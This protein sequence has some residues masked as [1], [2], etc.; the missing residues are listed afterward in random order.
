MQWNKQRV[1][2]RLI[3]VLFGVV[4]PATATA[5]PVCAGIDACASA[6]DDGKGNLA[7]CTELG[8]QLLLPGPKQAPKRAADAFRQGCGISAEFSF[9][10]NRGEA[11]ACW[12]L[13]QLRKEGWL[14]IV[15]RDMSNYLMLVNRAESLAERKCTDA[16]PSGCVTAAAALSALHSQIT[17]TADEVGKPL[18]LA[19]LGCV[20]GKDFGACRVLRSFLWNLEYRDQKRDDAERLRKA[21]AQVSLST[22]I[23]DGGEACTIAR[24]EV[25]GADLQALQA[26]VDKRCTDGVVSECA[27][28]YYWTLVYEAKDEA[29]THA[30]AEKLYALCNDNTNAMC[31]PLFGDL[32]VG[33]VR[34]GLKVEPAAALALATKRCD[35]GDVEACRVVGRVFS[36]SG[37]AAMRDE[38]KSLI[39][40]E[41]ACAGTVPSKNCSE[42]YTQPEL[43]SCK[44]RAAVS[45]YS[46]CVDSAAVGTCEQ[47]AN[48]FLQGKLVDKDLERGAKLLRRGCDSADKTA[49]TALEDVCAKNPELPAESCAQALI[50]NDLFYEA[51]YQLEAGGSLDLVD[52]GKTPPA[53]PAGT[54]TVGDVVAN[55]PTGYQRGK[56]DADL[57]VN[58]VLDR[59]RQ[60]AVSLVVDKLM[61]AEQLSR[62]Q[63][64]RD[65][66][67]QGAGL[68][69]DPSTLRRE[70]FADLGMTV[71]R[72]FV[73]ANLIDSLYPKGRQFRAVPLATATAEA[74]KVDVKL[75]LPAE[76]HAYLVDVAYYWLG[77]TRLFGSGPGRVHLPPIC[78][79]PTGA[80]AQFCTVM[81]ERVNAERLI[82]VDKV[83]DGLRLAKALH[84]GGFD[85]LRRLIEAASHSRTIADFANTP[86][87][88]LPTWQSSIIG[89]SRDRIASLR[90]G[91][92]SLRVLGRASVFSER[93]MELPQLLDHAKRAR[94]TLALPGTAMSI[95]GEH[96]M[97][98][99]RLIALIEAAERELHGADG[100]PDFDPITDSLSPL[101]DRPTMVMTK[102]RHDA[103]DGHNAW[104]AAGKIEFEKKL[105]GLDD[106]MEQVSPA[107]ARLE[108]TILQIRG[109][110]ARY[111]GPD[112]RPAT[113]V[114]SLPL[115]AMPELKRELQAALAALLAVDEGL[116]RL[117]P[118]QSSSQLRFAR[119]TTVRLL[120]FL[121]LMDRIARSSQLSM[122]AGDVVAALRI[123]GGTQIGVFDAPLYDVL[124]PV[125]DAIRT[126]EPMSLELLFSVIA[127]VR[128]DSLIGALQGDANACKND[129]S[130]D[131]WTTKLLHALQESVERD[132]GQVRIDGGKFAERL[133]NH[134]DDFRKRHTWRGFLHLTVG[135]GGLY[136]DPVT[137]AGSARRS[138][139]LIAEQIGF[140]LASPAFWKNRLTFKVGAAASGVLYRALLD[141]DESNAIM[142]HPLFF[143]LDVTDLVEVYVSPAMMMFYPPT[144]TSDTAFRWGASIGVSVPLSAYLERR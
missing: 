40:A 93:G 15:D 35:A 117:A 103:I 50:H 73:A 16:D 128:L 44:M 137:D 55:A 87:L 114:D 105:A 101:L 113:N 43:A 119:S 18:K 9:D 68:L 7:A 37:P 17:P 84:D 142:V 129:S 138:T 39:Y 78:P 67:T 36:K 46:K 10:P 57:V 27:T 59:A 25:S 66:L 34:F 30:A 116:R 124:E 86:G 14:F 104:G 107:L 76:L 127:H 26:A 99:Y 41:R 82:G 88:S 98:L 47:A 131:C 125:I 75:A 70:K 144:E 143:A 72:A 97:H 115:Y 121:D 5:G 92:T 94:T 80:P 91:L 100:K 122:R 8:L 23:R 54:V 85:D 12:Q 134:G 109:L 52:V 48:V 56:L 62:H 69:A 90:T 58:V 61:E 33:R 71:V 19:E 11:K 130:V 133:A 60:A 45:Q 32:I 110:F 96:T 83:L 123:L 42:C 139:P 135:V 1:I 77:E 108:T 53:R 38:A 120:G 102:L 136:T 95:G 49:C 2:Q 132:N 6:C 79:W 112:G 64:L 31:A 21:I 89:D 29:K 24:N 74:L 63:Y 141:S 13:A 126:H 20:T 3:V 140:G 51:E 65:L 28:K 22:C 118:G 111:P 81:S 4:A 106:A